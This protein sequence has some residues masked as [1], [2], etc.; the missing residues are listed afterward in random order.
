MFTLSVLREG[1]ARGFLCFYPARPEN[2]RRAPIP[3]TRQNST[4]SSDSHTYAP[5]RCNSNVSPTYAKT[6]GY[7]PQK[8]RRADIFSLILGIPTFC[9]PRLQRRRVF[10]RLRTL[11]FSV[12]HLSPV[13]SKPFALFAKK[14]GVCPQ[15]G[16]TNSIS[17]PPI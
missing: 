1:F 8:C 4:K 2:N 5:L 15:R 14:P 17:P 11:S 12:A 16:H 13:P 9:P 7:T 3:V 10:Y 6:G